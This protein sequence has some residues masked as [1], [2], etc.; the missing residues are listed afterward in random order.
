MVRTGQTRR[1]IINRR[2]GPP[3]S[4]TFDLIIHAMTTPEDALKLPRQALEAGDAPK[5][6]TETSTTSK[7]ETSTTDAA[8]VLEAPPFLHEREISDAIR[9]VNLIASG[10]NPFSDE[11]FEKLRPDQRDAV[12]QALC[13]TVSALV[14]TERIAVPTPR[15]KPPSQGNTDPLSKR[16]LEEYL[17]RLE[18]EAIIEALE[19]THHNRTAAA[20]LLGITF[21]ALRY[22]LENLGLEE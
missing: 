3:H 20:R 2:A 17:Q 10:R 13:V 16:P 14:Q 18:R 7:S 5:S 22:R 6:T 8:A 11:P 12:L 15:P 4:K 19:E 9:V 21:R 1:A